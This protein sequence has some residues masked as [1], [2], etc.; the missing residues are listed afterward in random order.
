MGNKLGKIISFEEMVAN[1]KK[2]ESYVPLC[3]RN[4]HKDSK[5]PCP[6]VCGEMCVNWCTDRCK[7]KD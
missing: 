1:T 4:L 6:E 3:Q 5:W 2:L 7:E